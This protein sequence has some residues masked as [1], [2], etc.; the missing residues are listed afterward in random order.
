ME[1]PSLKK[2]LEEA[3][4]PSVVIGVDQQMK[5][6]GQARTALQAFGDMLAAE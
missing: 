4:I 3:E 5:D 1:Y 2:A 6:F